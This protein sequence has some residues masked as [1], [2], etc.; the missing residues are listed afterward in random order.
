MQSHQNSSPLVSALKTAMDCSPIGISNPSI[1]QFLS[2]SS[3]NQFGQLG[4]EFGLGF[5]LGD[6]ALSNFNSCATNEQYCRRMWYALQFDSVMADSPSAATTT[7]TN[8]NLNIMDTSS[9]SPP[10]DMDSR[11]R[12]AESSLEN[13]KIKRSNYGAGKADVTLLSGIID[14]LLSLFFTLPLGVK[15]KLVIPGLQ[16]TFPVLKIS[17]FFWN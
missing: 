7:I 12:N 11:K 9:I 10:P 6:L 3:L 5:E 1:M 2:G 8:N 15:D 17:I 13:G 4:L 14:F 16:N